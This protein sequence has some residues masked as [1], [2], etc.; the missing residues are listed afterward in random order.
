MMMSSVGDSYYAM[1]SLDG[2]NWTNHNFRECGNI[3]DGY[4]MDI[5]SYNKVGD[6]L[7]I[8]VPRQRAMYRRPIKSTTTENM[9]IKTSSEYL[10]TEA[11]IKTS[12]FG[13]T[14][15]NAYMY[16][17]EKSGYLA[18]VTMRYGEGTENRAKILF[19]W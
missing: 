18:T 8:S 5:I 13:L 19:R 7:Y 12:Y 10:S 14:D 1:E 6:Y 9:L 3:S 4:E 17:F 16:Y 2:T 15:Q 11:D